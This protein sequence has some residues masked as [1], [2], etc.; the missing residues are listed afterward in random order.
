MARTPQSKETGETV[1]REAAFARW[2]IMQ[3]KRMH[4]EKYASLVKEAWENRELRARLQKDPVSVLKEK[5]I[6]VPKGV[7]VHVVEESP[8]QMWVV[9]PP[10][11]ESQAKTELTDEQLE[12]RLMRGLFSDD[13]NFYDGDWWNPGYTGTDFKDGDR[14]GKGKAD[15]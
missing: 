6:V 12:S 14:K 15:D 5:G 3:T 10:P 11:I 1:V 2:L 7:T 13:S 8:T 4:D 9:L